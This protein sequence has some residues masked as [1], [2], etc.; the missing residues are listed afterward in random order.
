[1]NNGLSNQAAAGWWA[2]LSFVGGI[3]AL[4][5]VIVGIDGHASVAYILSIIVI[6]VS[7]IAG[8]ALGEYDE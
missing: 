5:S 2:I 8:V 4:T 6:I 7:Q 1:M 3:L